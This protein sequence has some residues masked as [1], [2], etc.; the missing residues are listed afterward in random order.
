MRS[1]EAC[2]SSRDSK[3]IY[4]DSADNAPNL[5]R[6]RITDKR[7]EKVASLREIRLTPILGGLLNGLAPDDSPLAVLDVGNQ[8]I[9]SLD[10]ELP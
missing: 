7:L 2:G 1:K 3:F 6:V 10:V 8:E 4:F 5:C 9:Y